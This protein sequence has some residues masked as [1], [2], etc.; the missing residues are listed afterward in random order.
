[1]LDWI[2]FAVVGKL[3]IYFWQKFPLPQAL[4]KRKFIVD[5]HDCALC[6]GVWVYTGLSFLLRVNVFEEFGL[7]YVLFLSELVTGCA[8]SYVVH[9]INVG[10]T[11]YHTTVIIE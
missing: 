2:I 4:S 11:E 1:M 7:G 8:I 3:I 9:L 6:S 10:F 5:L